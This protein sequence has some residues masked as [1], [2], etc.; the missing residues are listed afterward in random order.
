MLQWSMVLL[1]GYQLRHYCG[2]AALPRTCYCATTALLLCCYC[3]TSMLLLHR[4]TYST[5]LHYCCKFL[6]S[7]P[8]CRCTATHLLL[9]LLPCYF[10]LTVSRGLLLF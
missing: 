6:L 8:R 9:L 2:T 5:G 7:F 3:A 10:R 1:L 4:H